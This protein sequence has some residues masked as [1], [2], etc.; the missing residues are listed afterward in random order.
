MKGGF[1]LNLALT[2]FLFLFSQCI[3][4]YGVNS[5][6]QLSNSQII[7]TAKKY[8]IQSADL[9]L[10]DTSYRAY[11]QSLPKTDSN[12]L[13]IPS[14][15]Y[16]CH[17][18]HN[19]FQPLQIMFF[20]KNDDLV[21]YHV[22]CDIAGFP[23]LKWNYSGNFNSFLPKSTTYCDPF[24][25]FDL[26]SLYI[27]M[28]DERNINI[29][30]FKKNEYNVV[31]FWCRFMGRQSKRLVKFVYSYLKANKNHTYNILFV[32]VDSFGFFNFTKSC[33]AEHNS[34]AN[35]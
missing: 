24:A 26:L 29:S 32:N 19:H 3:G 11:L 30:S 6:K 20:D 22:N 31:V 27:K 14:R 4:M 18:R 1:F 34:T 33:S 28:P 25:K 21:S 5:L 9:Y 10:L 17:I 2:G 15:I 7:K 8:K 16:Q 13:K 23:N 35:R 12:C